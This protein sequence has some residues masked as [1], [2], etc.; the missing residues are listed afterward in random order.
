MSF[1]SADGYRRFFQDVS[2]QLVFTASTDDT[3]LVT[4]KSTGHTLFIQRIIVY[5]TTDAAQS[6]VFEDSNSG[7]RKVA[8][9]PASPGDETR[10]DFDF[11]DR[12]F[13][14][15]EGKNFVMNVS[16]AGLAGHLEWYGYQKLTGVVAASSSN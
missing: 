6:M 16:A 14:L 4:V 7:P 9:V 3:T 15:T 13:G 12:G 10:W 5:I 11:G 8:E 2:G 1:L